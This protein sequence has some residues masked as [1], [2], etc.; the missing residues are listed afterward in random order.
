MIQVEDMSVTRMAKR[1]CHEKPPG[2]Q[3]R[4]LGNLEPRSRRSHD[5]RAQI[6]RPG[7]IHTQRR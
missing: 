2:L 3:T 6:G 1:N 5:E 4:H 7:K